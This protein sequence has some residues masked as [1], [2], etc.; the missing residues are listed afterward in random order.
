MIYVLGESKIR[1]MTSY[2]N[3]N[4]DNDDDDDDVVVP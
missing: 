1:C 3:S 2:H 4:I